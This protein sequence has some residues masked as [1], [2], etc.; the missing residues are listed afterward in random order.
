MDLKTIKGVDHFLYDNIQE[1]KALTKNTC[2]PKEWRSADEGDWVYTDDGY[3]CQILKK[4]TVKSVYRRLTQC[5]RTVCGTF[6]INRKKKML[7]EDGVAQNI[8]TFSGSTP[9]EKSKGKQV[10]F[11]RYIA[12]GTDP[13]KAY[14]NTFPNAKSDDYIKRETSKLLKTSKVQTMI[15]KE[16]LAVL[17]K[18]GVTPEWIVDR[19]K[20]I[21]DMA[22]RDT[23]KL[24]SLENLTKISGLFDNE[25]KKS[26][27]LTV[28]AG[29]KPE[30]LEAL[31]KNGQIKE[32]AHAE[33]EQIKAKE[34]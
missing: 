6:C 24:R 3:I 8:F 16:T 11:A 25:E 20:T 9:K 1:F 12:T 7:G 34:G 23:D 2:T 19:Y 30:Q 4:F 29:F 18:K 26:E 17:E 33:R 5:V 10:M 14:K 31:E 32:I 21:A 22:E 28:F 15:K 27:Q 13:Q